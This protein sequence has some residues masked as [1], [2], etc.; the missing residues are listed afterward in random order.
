MLNYFPH[1]VILIFAETLEP[2][3]GKCPFQFI[4]FTMNLLNRFWRLCTWTAQKGFRLYWTNT[5][6]ALNT[7]HCGG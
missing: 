7:K 4:G 6:L 3:N 1:Y 5:V 2:M